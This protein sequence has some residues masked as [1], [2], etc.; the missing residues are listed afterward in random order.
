MFMGLMTTAIADLAI[1]GSILALWFYSPLLAI[2][3][4]PL[5][6]SLLVLVVALIGPKARRTRHGMPVNPFVFPHSS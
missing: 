4:T 1:A 2:L 3:C 5:A 6:A